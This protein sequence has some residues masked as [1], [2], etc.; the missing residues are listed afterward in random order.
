A[1][2]TDTDPKIVALRKAVLALYDQLASVQTTL[3]AAGM[4]LRYG[5]VPYASTVNVGK[6]IYA[7]NP[8][9]MVSQA[10]YQTRTQKWAYTSKNSCDGVYGTYDNP[11]G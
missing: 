1:V 5:V 7:T 11:S 4:R 2:S 6:T 9:Y 8:N 3:Q 10:T